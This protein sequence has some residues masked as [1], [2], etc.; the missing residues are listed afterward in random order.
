MGLMFDFGVV[1]HGW[2]TKTSGFC[3]PCVVGEMCSLWVVGFAHSGSR[4]CC[5]GHG[6]VESM[7]EAWV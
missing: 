1:G 4:F 7:F 3:F 6:F 2:V 5:C